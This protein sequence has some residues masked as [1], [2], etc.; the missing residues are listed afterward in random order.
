MKCPFLKRTTTIR[1]IS[2]S[3][4]GVIGSQA[5]RTEEQAESFEPCLNKECMAWTEDLFGRLSNCLRLDGRKL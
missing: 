1:A 2:N 4:S 3:M 5:D